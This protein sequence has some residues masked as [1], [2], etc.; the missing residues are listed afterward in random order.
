MEGLRGD[1]GVCPYFKI[2]LKKYHLG[3][4]YPHSWPRKCESFGRFRGFFSGIIL[5]FQRPA[6]RLKRS[7]GHRGHRGHREKKVRTWETK[8]VR[9][10]PK[11][12]VPTSH[13]LAFPPSLFSVFLCDLC[14]SLPFLAF[15]RV[16][17]IFSGSAASIHWLS[18]G[19]HKAINASVPAE[20]RV[21]IPGDSLQL[22]GRFGAPRKRR[23]K[24]PESILAH[25]LWRPRNLLL[26][27][28][29]LCVMLCVE[30]S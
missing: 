17:V 6:L 28:T 7:Y 25:F 15:D 30:R 1:Q 16:I 24:P 23:P 29:R 13:V 10:C 26:I 18:A 22:W 8:K 11:K 12:K 5:I 27:H 2:P 14:G 21:A 9:R 3:P 20:G 4:L 19:T